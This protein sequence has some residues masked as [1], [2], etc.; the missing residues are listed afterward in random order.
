MT[1]GVDWVLLLVL[2]KLTRG[3][4]AMSWMFWDGLTHMPGALVE[5]LQSLEWLASHPPPPP[6][7]FCHPWIPQKGWSQDS[8]CESGSF[9]ATRGL[10]WKVHNVPFYWSN[11]NHGGTN[12]LYL[13]KK[14]LWESEAIFNPLQEIR[15]PC[16]LCPALSYPSL[17]K[18]R[19]GTKS[20]LHLPRL[21]HEH[22][23]V[24]FPR[25][26]LKCEKEGENTIQCDAML[27]TTTVKTW[28]NSLQGIFTWSRNHRP[29][30][31]TEL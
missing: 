26:Q 11:A 28:R 14:D 19:Q 25:V 7:W 22:L 6:T 2:L 30:N 24:G 21:Q 20:L 18:N 23:K 27:H 17:D 13:L 29:A 5:M 3:A 15:N 10:G 12:R 8:E 16:P 4:A 31:S 9:K 1:L